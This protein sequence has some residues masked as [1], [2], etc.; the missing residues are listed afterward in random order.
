LPTE[1]VD[2]L[3]EQWYYEIKD[4]PTR[5]WTTAQTLGFVKDGLITSQRGES[6]LSQMGYDSEHIAILFG[7]IESIPRTE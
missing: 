1:Q 5:T 4:E 6:E 7:S 3:M 2:V